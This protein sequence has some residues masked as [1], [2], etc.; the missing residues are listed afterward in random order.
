MLQ[1]NKKYN[2]IGNIL[3]NT[4]VN[5]MQNNE[6]LQYKERTTHGTHMAPFARYRADFSA[7]FEYNPIH[8]HEEVEI[9]RV[10]KGK[11]NIAVNGNWYVLDEGDIMI[12]CP[13]VMH[14]I[15]KYQDDP[16]EVDAFVFNLRLLE[17][18]TADAC[19]LKYFAPLLNAQQSTPCILKEGQPCYEMANECVKQI[20]DYSAGELGY[21]LNIKANLY[22][23]FYHVFKNNLLRAETDVTEGKKC[24]AVRQALEYIRANYNKEITIETLAKLCGY[25]E[26]YMMKMFKR[27]TGVTCIDYVNNHRLNIAGEML[28]SDKEEISQIAY[29]VGYNN[30]SYFNRQFKARYGMTPKEFRH[31]HATNK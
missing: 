16:S 6:K 20:F 22:W 3:H 18:S 21:E 31:S 1:T 24:Y 17:T 2:I 14:S 15:N 26:F 25:S 19:T 8:W 23:L 9:I 28:L 29:K 12:L 27:F 5:E 13:Y 7:G 10:A 30:I 11:G 4:V